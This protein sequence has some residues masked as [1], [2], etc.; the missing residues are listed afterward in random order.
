MKI[1]LNREYFSSIEKQFVEKDS[2]SAVLF[3]YNTGISAVKLS[4]SF[5][6]I[7]V[8]PFNGLMIWDAAFGG[9]LLKMQTPCI[10]PQKTDSFLDTYGC[11]MMHCGALS[12]GC[13]GENDNHPRH[14]ELPYASY[15]I[16]WITAGRDEKGEYLGVSGSFEFRSESGD[17]YV[18]LPETRLYAQD[19]VLKINIEVKNL[20]N[21]PMDFMYLCHINNYPQDGGRIVQALP[22]TNENM[23]IRYS[24]PNNGNAQ[25]VKSFVEKIETDRSITATM[26]K[27]DP[28]DPEICF[29]LEK[30]KADDEGFS[31]LL[32]IH[33]D[34][35]AD[36][37]SYM[38]SQLDHCTRW[39]ANTKDMK[40][41]GMALP[42]TAD[43]EGYTAEKEKG[44][45]KTIAP[46]ESFKTTILAGY[47]NKDR[48]QEMENI[49]LDLNDN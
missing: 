12:M 46:K 13:P 14:G 41:M 36:Y 4:N 44:N 25:N 27:E 37:T 39:I 23:Q 28:Y 11:Y 24:I 3:K 35:S 2:L 18:A 34:G 42:A 26:R 10:I 29:F 16:T 49:I 19:T 48:A 43:A 31:H 17:N 20:A 1:E 6:F 38:P 21:K 40:A 22:W 33:A 30:P 47:L 45:I 5:G 15:D 7:T 9:R 8:L 32:F